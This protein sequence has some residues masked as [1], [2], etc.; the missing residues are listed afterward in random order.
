MVPNFLNP[1]L[2]FGFLWSVSS[3]T[4]CPPIFWLLNLITIISS[5][6]LLFL[7]SLFFKRS[8][9]LVP[10]KTNVRYEVFK[11]SFSLGTLML[12]FG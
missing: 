8:L 1:N 7:V 5:P 9:V 3:V 4:T 12:H 10:G 11:S 6:V 2:G